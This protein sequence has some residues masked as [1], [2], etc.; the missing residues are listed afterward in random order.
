MVACEN[1]GAGP[2][3]PP[4]GPE[5]SGGADTIGRRNSGYVYRTNWSPDGAMRQKYSFVDFSILQ[6]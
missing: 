1:P 5:V 3:P 6:G 4:I 2:A